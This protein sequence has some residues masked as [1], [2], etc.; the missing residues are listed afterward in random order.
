MTYCRHWSMAFRHHL[1][2]RIDDRIAKDMK[3]VSAPNQHWGHDTDSQKHI[4]SPL[5]GEYDFSEV[6]QFRAT[7]NNDDVAAIL[8]HHWVHCKDY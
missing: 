3:S 5:K 1:G 7:M 8:F 4:H 6:S 2:R